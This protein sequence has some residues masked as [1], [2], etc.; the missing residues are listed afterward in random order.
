MEYKDNWLLYFTGITRV[1]KNILSEIV[2]GMFLNEGQRLRILDEIKQHA[3][4]MA[5]AMQRS[6]YNLTAGMIARSW[7]LNNALDS[8]TNTPE[9]QQIISHISDLAL[10]FKLPG[11]GGGGYMLI[12][13]RDKDA[14]TRIQ[15]ILNR[16]PPNKKARFV[17]MNVSQVG[18]QVTR[19]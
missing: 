16:N 1:A 14:A 2:R 8:G 6:D 10:G 4:H 12:A 5:E 13:A 7:K 18:F 11:A 9:I 3:Y 19:S 17:K 15:A